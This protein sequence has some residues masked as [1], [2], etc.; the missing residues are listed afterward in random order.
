LCQISE[1][2]NS[3]APSIRWRLAG[4]VSDCDMVAVKLKSS[5]KLSTK[6]GAFSA[7]KKG[8][9]AQLQRCPDDAS[10]SQFM[11]EESNMNFET[12]RLP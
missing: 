9:L 8:N 2:V 1:R 6:K 12:V 3:S 11:S 7:K 10:R 5:F 4:G